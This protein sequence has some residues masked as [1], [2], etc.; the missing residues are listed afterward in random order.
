MRESLK[1]VLDVIL[2]VQELDMQM[3][4][5]INLKQA[6]LRDLENI[7]STR[8]EL[9]QKAEKKESDIL[10]LKK[11]IRLKEGKI[12]ECVAKQKKLESQQSSIKKVDE[13]NALSQEMSQ[14]DREKVLESQKLDEMSE[15]LAVESDLLKQLKE[16]YSTTLEGSKTLEVEIREAIR[17]I[18]EEGKALKSQRDDLAAL[19]NPD[20]FK[21]YERLLRNKRDRVVVPIE[22]RCCSGCHIMLTAQDENM[23]R[24][25]ERL[26]F[27][28]HCSRIHFWP[29]EPTAEA[30]AP[31]KQR[32][33]RAAK[34]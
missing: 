32:R 29:E 10:E 8:S 24:K 22:N 14:V 5:L 9:K 30:T 34:V 6:R 31:V 21:I 13:F 25:G 4:Q 27:C 33:R 17:H 2:Q 23:V 3:I 20:L 19:A 7:E 18:N 12:A 11:E 26:V 1:A 16:N 28:E 15:R